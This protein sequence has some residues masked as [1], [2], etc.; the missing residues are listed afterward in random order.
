MI[1]T[2]DRY[3]VDRVGW[4]T[5]AWRIYLVCIGTSF[6]VIVEPA[7]TDALF[8]LALGTLLLAK[9]RPVRLIGPIETIAILLF[10]WFTL[11]S[12]SSGAILHLFSALRAAGIQMYMILLFLVTAYFAHIGGD[13]AF[14]T[15]LIALAVAGVIAASIGIMAYLSI[16]PHSISGL[17]FRDEFQTRVSST[18]K[19]P[20]VLGPFLVPTVLFTLWLALSGTR[21]RVR[22]G[23][24][25]VI[26]LFCL[27]ITYSRGAWVHMA[28]SGLLFGGFL[29]L[30]RRTAMAT[31]GSTLAVIIAALLAASVLSGDIAAWIDDSYLGTRLSLQDY[32]SERFEAMKLALGWV[33]E[34]PFGLGPNQVSANYGRYP[35]NTPINLAVNNGVLA[36]VGFVL[37]FLAA[38]YRCLVKTIQQRA[39][40]IKYAF[41]L[42]VLMGLMVLINVVPALHWRH[43]YVVLGLAY[44]QYRSNAL[45]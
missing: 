31:F 21:H 35:H 11:F 28:I 33:A 5:L 23:A 24:A 36:A 1:Q 9:L 19:D 38:V 20:N 10:V 40:W 44:G 34:R 22:A 13:R 25:F 41:I 29:L 30:N 3:T 37:L 16:I 45:S 42:S 43:M 4:L 39:G 18:F 32:D 15:I 6:F 27:V 14:R 17:F 8:L 7:P 2:Y 12:L 26:C